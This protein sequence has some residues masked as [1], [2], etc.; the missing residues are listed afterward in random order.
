MRQFVV[1]FPEGE[2]LDD[3]GIKTPN[4]DVAEKLVEG[5]ME[6]NSCVI[7]NTWSVVEMLTD[8][9]EMIKAM[10]NIYHATTHIKSMTECRTELER[11]VK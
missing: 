2:T 1:T 3:K 11:W 4:V 8:R 10:R 7:P 6:G 5:L 9:D